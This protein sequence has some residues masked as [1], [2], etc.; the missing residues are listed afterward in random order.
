[1]LWPTLAW[2]QDGL[3]WKRHREP[4]IPLGTSGE[5]DRFNNSV[6]TQPLVVG[7][8]LWFYYSGRT[9]RHGPYAAKDQGPV[10]G[11]IGLAKLRLDGF[12]SL[13]ASF[14]GG[15]VVTRAFV[16]PA[17]E[18]FVNA[19]AEYGEV[20]VEVL[21][22]AG[23]PVGGYKSIPLEQDAVSVPVSWPEGRKLASLKRRT[24]SLRFSLRNARLY[25]FRI[26]GDPG[27]PCLSGP[28]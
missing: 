12:A 4:F 11:A 6:A 20:V 5:W 27:R 2:S 16:L 3:E 25:A 18:L 17:G 13:D 15:S 19:A 23:Q 7:D 24:V 22:E 8:E 1:M 14:D 28:R 26:G 21:G 10:W 9:Y